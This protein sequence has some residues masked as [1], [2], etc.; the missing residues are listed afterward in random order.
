MNA[1][2]EE[3]TKLTLKGDMY[4]HPV[5]TE[6]DREDAFLSHQEMESKRLCEFILNQ[7]PVLTE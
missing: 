1:R 7:E 5:K 3:L 6:Y 2:I 4:A